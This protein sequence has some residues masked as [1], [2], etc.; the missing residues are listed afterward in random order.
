M[1]SYTGYHAELYDHFY[2]KKPYKREVSFVRGCLKKYSASSVKNILD[3]ACGT[4]SHA[5]HLSQ[6]DYSITAADYSRDMLRVAARKLSGA[7]NVKVMYMDMLKFRKFSKPFDAVLCLF[8]SI[9]YVNTNENI[10]KVLEG[11]HNNLRKNGLFIVEF[12]NAGSMLRSF[13]PMRVRSWKAGDKKIT[14]KSQTKLRYFKQLADVSYSIS[15]YDKSRNLERKIR[16]TQTNRYFLVQEM[17]LFLCESGFKP[18][19]WFDGY[20][21]KTVNENSWHTV[22]VARRK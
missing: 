17:N 13:E 16:E 22:C 10:L 7:S 20:R 12:W 14:R 15:V 4:G 6:F 11:V 3:L 19:K 8:D 5:L 2:G 1:S 21:N 18:V 9:G